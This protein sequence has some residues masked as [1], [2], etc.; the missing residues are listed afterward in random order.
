VLIV[1]DILANAGGVVVSYFE[2]VHDLQPFFWVPG[3]VNARLREVMVRGYDAVR[4]RAQAE[5]VSLREAA[6]HIAVTKVAE[7]AEVRGIYP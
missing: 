5:K 1:P 2:W 4:A 7:A 3:E 6:Y